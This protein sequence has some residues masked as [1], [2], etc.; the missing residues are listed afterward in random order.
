MIDYNPPHKQTEGQKWQSIH[1]DAEKASDKIQFS[2][3]VKVLENLD[4]QRIYLNI[5]QAIY[6]KTTANNI[7]SGEKPKTLTLKLEASKIYSLSVP[8][9][10]IL[11]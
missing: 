2:F 8:L 11:V 1:V 7:P 6:S 9:F 5:I 10:N 3:M 4:I